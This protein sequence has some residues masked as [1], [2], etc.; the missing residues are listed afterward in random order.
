ML[1][2]TNAYVDTA[3]GKNKPAWT[4][5][6][7][8]GE[9]GRITTSGD[10]L[11]VFVFL[12]GWDKYSYGYHGDDGNAFCSS[13]PGVPYGPTFTTGDVVGCCVNLIDNTCFY[14]K[15]GVNL[16]KNKLVMIL[17]QEHLF[18]GLRK[19]CLRSRKYRKS[20]SWPEHLCMGAGGCF[21]FPHCLSSVPSWVFSVSSSICSA[22]FCCLFL[23]STFICLHFCILHQFLSLI[24][25][26]YSP[27]NGLR[28]LQKK[29]LFSLQSKKCNSEMYCCCFRDSSSCMSASHSCSVSIHC[30]FLGHVCVTLFYGQIG[31]CKFDLFF[32]FLHSLNI[33]GVQICTLRHLLIIN[34]RL[35]TTEKQCF[36][37]VK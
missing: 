1:S 9:R 7:M 3:C 20:K 16:G 29:T 36:F 11:N 19:V 37:C 13:N 27:K 8:G 22:I 33:F 34:S 5:V 35:F 26:L 31:Q 4:H 24:L 6:H 28:M 15:N 32:F 2:I 10:M 14:T 25:T 18:C 17:S 21:C 23:S 30:I 12:T